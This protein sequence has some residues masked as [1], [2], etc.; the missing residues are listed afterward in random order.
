MV[1]VNP[2][3][4]NRF[5]PVADVDAILNGG[6]PGATVTALLMAILLELRLLRAAGCEPDQ[7]TGV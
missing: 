3:I 1:E 4:G 7:G 5:E 2:E 6:Q